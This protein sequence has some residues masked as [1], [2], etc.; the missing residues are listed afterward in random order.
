MP[1]EALTAMID[2]V[3]SMGGGEPTI[4]DMRAQASGG[5]ALNPVPEDVTATLV[6]ADGVACELVT[7]P[8]ARDDRLV[9][10]CHG[11]GYAVGSAESSRHFAARVAK[12]ARARVLVVD[13]RLAPENPY[14]APLD[15]A[16]AAYR[17]ALANGP[18]AER[19]VVLGESSGGGLTLAMLLRAK[20]EGLPMPA[21]AVTLSP[22]TDLELS[23]ETMVSKA[24]A[25]PLVTASLLKML[26]DAYVQGQ[27]KHQPFVS[28]LYGDFDGFP[29]L[30]IQVGTAEI[31]L[32]D[33]RRLAQAAERAGVPVVLDVWDDMIHTWQLFA[34]FVP[35][36]QEAIE[37]FS[38]AIAQHLP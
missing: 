28:P 24:S 29:P 2:M 10:H 34:G 30:Y 19:T 26:A 17:W 8:E 7:A 18:G 25:D 1:S 3:R 35:E 15:D 12:A 23:G 27:D 32:D 4:E 38:S 21:V 13:Y 22:W 33:S 31:L 14:P 37:K 6:D 20:N 11:G 9:V 5:S 36:G 16:V